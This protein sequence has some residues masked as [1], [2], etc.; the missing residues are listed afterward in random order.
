MFA[1]NHKNPV[2]IMEVN[3]AQRHVC[4]TCPDTLRS[5]SITKYDPFIVH[6]APHV[7]FCGN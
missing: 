6:S 7:Y 3:L 2:D 4:P 1:E 5:Y